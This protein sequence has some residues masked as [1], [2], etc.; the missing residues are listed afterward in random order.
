M[1]TII[2]LTGVANSGKDL[3]AEMMTNKMRRRDPDVKL[4]SLSFASPIK[5]AV[6]A[7]L[8]CRIED[9]DDRNFKE[10]SLID[11]HGLDTSPRKMMQLMGDQYARQMIDK[12][13]WIK[14]A[15]QR[16]ETAK[17]Q[18]VD[19][20]FITDLRYNNEQDWVLDNGGV[21]VCIERN[22]AVPVAYHESEAGLAKP[23]CY[24]IYNNGSIEDLRMEVAEM[25]TILQPLELRRNSID[26]CTPAEWDLMRKYM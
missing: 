3:T 2:A 9:F 8:G 1:T 20:M 23:P 24:V 15:Q 16:L 10:G 11:S 21:V 4:R 7:I 6:S 22:D 17:A 26:D 25:T 19:Y 18:G 5:E 13:I 14:I 12:D